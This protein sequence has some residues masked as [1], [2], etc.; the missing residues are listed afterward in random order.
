MDHPDDAEVITNADGVVFMFS[1]CDESSYHFALELKERL[2]TKFVKKG[3]PG[4]LVASMKDKK[5]KI[6]KKLEKE[7]KTTA[8][9]FHMKFQ[10]IDSNSYLSS[11]GGFIFIYYLLFYY[12]LF[13]HYYY[14]DYYYYYY[15]YF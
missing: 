15:Y 7:A 5:S 11:R 6:K 10:K 2:N 14:Y 12:L 13:Y 3:V 9:A 8:K 4:I 1:I